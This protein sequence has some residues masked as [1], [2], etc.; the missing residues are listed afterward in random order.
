VGRNVVGLL[1]PCG[2]GNLGD[3]A[4]QSVAI[5]AVRRLRPGAD[6]EAF[7]LNPADTAQRHG[8]AAYP[9][10]AYAPPR[11][12]VVRAPSGID[13]ALKR[14]GRIPGMYRTT[15]A[16]RFGA[17]F[18]LTEPSHVRMAR[19]RLRRM[20]VLVVSG[21][22][23][24]DE[25]WGGPFGHPYA[26]WKW[27]VLA[28][29]ARTRVVALSLGAGRLASPVSRRFVRSTLSRVAY[30]SYRDSQTIDIVRGLGVGGDLRLAP[31][32]AF[33]IEPDPS[34]TPADPN[35]IGISPIAYQDPRVWPVADP[36]AYERY[37]DQLARF[38][39]SLTSRGRA[40]VLFTTNPSDRR[41][42]EAVHQRAGRPAAARVAET[43]DLAPL[44]R[45]LQAMHLAVASRLHGVMLSHVALRPTVAVSY[46][47]K[48][49]R[50][51]ESIAQERFCVPIDRIDA[52]L[53]ETVQRLDAEA[54]QVASTVRARVAE[55]RAAVQRQFDEVLG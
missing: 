27:S 36:L 5:D 23:Q 20:D 45:E 26:L 19:S 53:D 31:D 55:H 8:V 50:H 29:A 16:A 22:G 28:R 46:D 47:W 11:Y 7:T 44:W 51:M 35:L 9:I 4:I 40:V 42:A 38:V 52:E 13:R 3:A 15:R 54:P 25:L 32:L 48:V 1:S 2:W 24:L 30:A 41:T 37:V 49:D 10:S 12:G 39:G 17:A 21:G 43:A 34:D 18:W 14:A 33:G 6:I